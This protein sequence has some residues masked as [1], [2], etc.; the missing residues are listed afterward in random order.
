MDRPPPLAA[1]CQDGG[2]D[3]A[4]RNAPV[5]MSST[6]SSTTPGSLATDGKFDCLLACAI[7]K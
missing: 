4:A 3:N 7:V 1:A 6:A 5:K 2:V